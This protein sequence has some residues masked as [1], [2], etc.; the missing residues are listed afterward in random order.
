MARALDRNNFQNISAT[1]AA[2]ELRG[3]KYLAQCVA[4]FSAGNVHLQ[5]LGPDGTT[6]QDVGASTNF[7]VAGVAVVDLPNAQYRWTV[8]TAT[9]V[10][11]SVN[12]I[13][14]D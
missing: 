11:V 1:T 5:V 8:T 9:A 7:T 2:F 12:R 3:G 14:G 6:W 10:Y 13:P 4:T